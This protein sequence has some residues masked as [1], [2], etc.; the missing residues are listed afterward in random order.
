VVLVFRFQARACRD[1]QAKVV[2]TKW[3]KLKEKSE[4]FMERTIKEGTCKKEDDTNNMWE[5]MTT[6]IWKVALEVCGVTKGSGG[7]AKDTWW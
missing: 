1:K 4:V 5:K 7:K 3:W 2:R 6:C